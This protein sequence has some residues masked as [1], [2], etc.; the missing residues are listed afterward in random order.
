MTGKE[1]FSKLQSFFEK[2]EEAITEMEARWFVFLASVVAIIIVKALGLHGL[3]ILIALI[4]IMYF[5]T[6][7]LK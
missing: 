5:V 1:F 6:F 4:Y 3:G 2:T 7:L